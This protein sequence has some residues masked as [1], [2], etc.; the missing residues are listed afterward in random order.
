M[1]HSR[2]Y[3]AG[4]IVPASTHELNVARLDRMASVDGS[5][6]QEC[7]RPAVRDPWA[8]VVFVLSLLSW[9]IFLGILWGVLVA[10]P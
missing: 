4:G 3:R 7:D 6:L 8:K 5:W 2:L 1:I 10:L 9:A